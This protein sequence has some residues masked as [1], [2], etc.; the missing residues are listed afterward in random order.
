MALTAASPALRLP[1]TRRGAAQ[2]AARAGR[3]CCRRTRAAATTQATGH[4]ASASASAVASSSDARPSL[5]WFTPTH[6]RL[7]DH[8]ALLAAASKRSGAL[9]CVYVDDEETTHDANAPTTGAGAPPPRAAAVAAL[10]AALRARGGELLHRR[11]AAA[12]VLPALAAELGVGAVFVSA[13]AEATHADAADAAS[14]ALAA[15]GVPLRVCAQQ[16]WA[17]PP[18]GEGNWRRH[19]AARGAPLPPLPAPP[20]DRFLPASS[21][22]D[23]T[24]ASTASYD[25]NT[26]PYELS[27]RGAAAALRAYVGMPLPDDDASAAAA[28]VA[29]A[30]ALDAARRGTSYAL[31]FGRAASLGLLSGRRVAAAARGALAA[32]LRGA[33]PDVSAVARARC[34]LEAAERAAFHATLALSDRTPSS[35]ASADKDGLTRRW[36]R[37]RGILIPYVHAPG[38]PGC[39]RNALL[40]HGFGAFGEHWRRNIPALAAD[41][42]SVWAPTLPGFGRTEK[43]ALPFSQELW[44]SFLADFVQQ[45]VQA[46]VTVAGNSIGGFMAANL[47]ADYP[48]LVNGLV[49]VNSAGPVAPT[50]ADADADAGR[51]PAAKKAPPALLVN[52]LTAALLWYLERNVPTTLARCYPVNPG[53][54]D[55]WLADE[56]LRAAADPGAAAVFASVFYLPPPRSLGALVQ[57]SGVRTLILNGARDPL[58]DAVKRGRDL[59][60]ECARRGLGAAVRLQLVEAGHCPHDEAPEEINTAL[61]AFIRGAAGDDA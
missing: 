44:T 31:L 6:L 16:A 29:A 7:E 61:R 23:A 45:V 58:N 3:S 1:L 20:A 5:V 27:E 30:A 55:A 56:I 33:L 21:A 57:R 25:D 14:A 50:A 47:A 24:S 51:A 60:A 59:E 12:D 41:T 18:A 37:W 13:E 8:P 38:P 36:W 22:A 9:A 32:H 34:A 4:S 10:R 49:L 19:A 11:G 39:E 53:N 52:A 35:S 43:G 46:P 54:A 48:S 2:R 42:C 40:V 15:A 26:L 28:V 17:A